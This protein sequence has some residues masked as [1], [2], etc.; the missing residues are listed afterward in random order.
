MCP[1][2]NAVVINEKS[3]SELL[4]KINNCGDNGGMS[5]HPMYRPSCKVLE[6]KKDV[7]VFPCY[8]PVDRKDLPYFSTYI[9][10]EKEED[11]EYILFMPICDGSHFNGY[12]VNVEKK[13]IITI[14]SLCM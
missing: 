5:R 14:D 9:R 11:E 4:K 3:R 10:K 8:S 2:T 1:D 7:Q 13:E 12:V 6:E